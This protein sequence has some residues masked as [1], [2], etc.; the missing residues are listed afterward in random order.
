MNGD[1]R[2]DKIVTVVL[3]TKMS[4]LRHTG[5][6]MFECCDVKNVVTRWRQQHVHTMVTNNSFR[7]LCLSGYIC[8]YGS[9]EADV[10][11]ADPTDYPGYDEDWKAIRDGP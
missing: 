7:S 5:A 4:M 2:Q 6:D 11:F 3:W 9:T 1:T 10:A 8:D